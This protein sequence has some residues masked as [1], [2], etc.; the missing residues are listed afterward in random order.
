MGGFEVVVT[1]MFWIVTNYYPTSEVT[2][3]KG[4]NF[5][6]QVTEGFCNIL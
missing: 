2:K 4:G 5:E 3:E 1:S 6:S